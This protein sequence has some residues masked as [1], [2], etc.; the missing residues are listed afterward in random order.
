[1]ENLNAIQLQIVYLKKRMSLFET[2]CFF[3][4]HFYLNSLF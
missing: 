2:S 3:E 1:M 4:N